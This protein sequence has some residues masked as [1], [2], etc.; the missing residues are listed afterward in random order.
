MS[1]SF[2]L[3]HQFIN[4]TQKLKANKMRINKSYK[5]CKRKFLSQLDRNKQKVHKNLLSYE[6]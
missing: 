2:R 6:R 1:N 5:I 4:I 3:N